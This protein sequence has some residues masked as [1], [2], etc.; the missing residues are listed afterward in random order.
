MGEHTKKDTMSRTVLITALAVAA[1]ACLCLAS[2][3]ED[4][5]VQPIKK[6]AKLGEA[7]K[8]RSRAGVRTGSFAGTLMTSGS[9]TMIRATLTRRRG[10]PAAASA[11][12]TSGRPTI[13]TLP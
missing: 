2:E 5:G 4:L 6:A 1:I 10:A 12:A 13:G 3:V 11:T 7:A 8:T 9:F